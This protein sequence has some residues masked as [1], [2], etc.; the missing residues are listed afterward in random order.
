M[1]IGPPALRILLA[2]VN[3]VGMAKTRFSWNGHE[4]LVFDVIAPAPRWE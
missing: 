4:V 1:C 3:L 2:L